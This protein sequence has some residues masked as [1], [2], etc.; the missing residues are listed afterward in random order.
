MPK[1]EVRED[2][3]C[4]ECGGKGMTP[5][6]DR[7]ISGKARYSCPGCGFR[8][9][10]T[11][12]SKP[13]I[14]PPF[15]VGE[16]RK[17][18]R[19]IIT[20]AVNDT[21]LVKGAHETFI[22][23]AKELNACYLVI[24]GVYKNPDLA[25]MGVM[26]NYSWPEE[27]LPYI[28]NANVELT[29]HLRIKGATRI[30]YTAV[31]PLQGAN[32]AGDAKSE[33]FG[34][35]QVAMEMVA[36]PKDAPPKMLRTTGSIS[37]KNY[38]GS[39]KGQKAEFHHKIGAA[40]IELE[41]ANFWANELSYNGEG[42]YLYDRFYTPKSSR[43]VKSSK[44][45]V[46]GDT[47]K[48]FLRAK[49]DK[50]L[51]DATK[52]LKPKYEVFH[53]LHDHHV[54]SHHHKKDALHHLELAVKKEYSVREE[55]M[56]SVRFLKSKTNPV[57]VE[58][59]HHRHLDQ[60]FNRGQANNQVDADLYFEL[61]AL[62]KQAIEKGQIPDLF[63]LFCEEYGVGHVTWLDGNKKFVIGETD[64][65]QHGDRGPNGAKGTGK[66]FAKSGIKTITGHAHTPGIHKG[67][68]TVG[69]SE[70]DLPYAKG[71]TTWMNTHAIIYPD[72]NSTLFSIIKDKLPPLLR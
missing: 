32:H 49:T 66:S 46:F 60:W 28:C 27:I 69:V 72:G 29:P 64:V 3:Y 36:T 68:K 33:I 48:R 57:V 65:S 62:A 15:K 20:S 9:T 21:G 19:F 59:N 23:M 61:G 26:S 35:P 8:T 40:F 58:S 70:T 45:I 50:L 53:D 1:K 31:N 71:Y 5:L 39:W 37:V 30:Q 6:S 63:R 51:N 52:K 38:S 12:Y 25:H 22:K 7:A 4:P 41:G 56:Q 55:L 11:L 2:L 18:K 17:Y 67:N 42:V 13:Q 47:H 43:R 24:P 44:A 54:G 10:T 34:H 16:I 14:L